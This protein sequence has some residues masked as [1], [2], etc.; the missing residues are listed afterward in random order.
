MPRVKRGV[1]IL[2]HHLNFSAEIAGKAPMRLRAMMQE[3]DASAPI[4]IYARE[5][6]QQR[7]L[8]AT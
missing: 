2:E 4:A 5:Y 6:S 3:L 8:A 1:R 7:R